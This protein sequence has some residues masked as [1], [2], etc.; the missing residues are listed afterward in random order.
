MDFEQ[1]TNFYI[2]KATVFWGYSVIAASV[3]LTKAEIGTSYTVLSQQNSKSCGIDLVGRQQVAMKLILE[4]G[5]R[6]IHLIEV[7]H[8]IPRKAD[9]VPTE[10]GAQE[11]RL[12]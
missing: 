1:E 4:A 5:T 11:T 6:E 7:P 9:C 12:V 8:M 10:P 2:F 3:S